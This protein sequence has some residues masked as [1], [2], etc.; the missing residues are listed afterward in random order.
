[1]SS[2]L[3]LKQQKEKKDEQANAVQNSAQIPVACLFEH[4]VRFYVKTFNWRNE[5]VSVR[6]GKRAPPSMS[7]PL[8]IVTLENGSTDVAPSVEDPFGPR[9]NLS[10]GMTGVSLARFREELAR[11]DELLARRVSLS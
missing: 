1:M 5:A 3:L 8:H 6:A 4:F 9:R 7:L 10:D 2:G 11:A